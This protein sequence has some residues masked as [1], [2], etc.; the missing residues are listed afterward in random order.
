MQSK[1]VRQQK[2]GLGI[3]SVALECLL[4]TYT[5]VQ[6]A[7]L[8]REGLG[9]EDVLTAVKDRAG[10]VQ[11]RGA[12]GVHH[13]LKDLAVH[14]RRHI[15]RDGHIVVV[16]GDIRELGHLEE[17]A[18]DVDHLANLSDLRSLHILG[19][20]ERSHRGGSMRV[21]ELGSTR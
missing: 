4:A 3:A 14:R 8:E 6:R 21:G 19:Q 16:N 9:G 15:R 1:K 12:V 20:L 5:Y 13:L 11:I 2:V 7:A 17:V 10:V 18:S